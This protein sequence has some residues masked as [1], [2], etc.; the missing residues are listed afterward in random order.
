M[1]ERDKHPLD[2]HQ[3]NGGKILLVGSCHC[4]AGLTFPMI[5]TLLSIARRVENCVPNRH[6]FKS[7]VEALNWS[8]GSFDA[9][10]LLC[11]E[12]DTVVHPNYIGDYDKPDKPIEGSLWTNFHG[13]LLDFVWPLLDVGRWPILWDFCQ[14]K[15]WVSL[16]Q[17]PVKQH[18][19]RCGDPSY[20]TW[21]Y[22]EH[23]KNDPCLVVEWS[24]SSFYCPKSWWVTLMMSVYFIESVP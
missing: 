4:H 23:Q 11:I 17:M 7:T 13:V 3:I 15:L 1:G 10:W 20:S 19:Y 8:Q 22:L 14:H 9:G 24:S 6:S 21:Q 2:F 16:S 12:V 18:S 5:L